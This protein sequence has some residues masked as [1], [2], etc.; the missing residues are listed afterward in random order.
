MQRNEFP[1]LKDLVLVGGGHS[2]LAV[3]KMFGMNPVRGVRVTLISR[4]SVTAY[5]GMIPGLIA[6]HYSFDEAHIDLRALCGAT[7]ACF[8]RATV[9][10][11]DLASRWVMCDGRPPI[12]FDLLS[13]NTGSTPQTRTVPGALEHVL[14]VKPIEKFLATWEQ[15]AL[16]RPCRIAVVGG[17]AGGVELAL[18]TQHR[19]RELLSRCGGDPGPQVEFH[20]VSDAP[21]LLPTHNAR[22]Q[23]LFARVLRE[24]GV[25]T[26]LNHRVV[27]V[28]ADALICE[29]GDAVRF[30]HVFWAT[31]AEAPE[32]I[33]ASGLRTDANGFVAVHDTLQSVSHPFV[34][35][36]GDVA[37]VEQHP[38]AKS[39]VFAVRQGA[40]LARN[41]RRVLEGESLKPFVPQK[42]FLSL[43]STGDQYAIA[44][45]GPWAFEGHWVW[46]M[47]D[48]IDRRWISKYQQ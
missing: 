41:L 4:D 38:R 23:A 18:A 16:E 24:R 10:G 21:V 27:R 34:F 13:I 17:G 47:K 32:W 44:S 30:D 28:E 36:A 42:Q 8:I 39:G 19:I 1:A 45:R 22:V 33:A 35:A 11:L 31:N 29:P 5:S 12:G 48:W 46:R 15:L 20:L 26:H 14:R 40:P 37:A 43:I 7:G 25:V 2:H 3:L 9:S 6:G